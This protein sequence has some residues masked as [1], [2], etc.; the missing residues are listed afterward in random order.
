[1][2]KKEKKI[3]EQNKVNTKLQSAQIYPE[4][5]HQESTQSYKP[6]IIIIII[7]IMYLWEAQNY[8]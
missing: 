2:K 3:E 4:Q 5:L 8:Q 1:M 7:L 6:Y